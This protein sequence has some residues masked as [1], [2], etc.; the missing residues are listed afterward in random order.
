MESLPL[1]VLLAS[2]NF[3]VVGMFGAPAAACYCPLQLSGS[4]DH[5]DAN[6]LFLF[7]I[8]T[9]NNVFEYG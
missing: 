3:A 8:A 7:C 4:D 1:C 6:H 2:I 5:N 9:T